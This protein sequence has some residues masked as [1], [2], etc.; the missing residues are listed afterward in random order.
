PRRRARIAAS[1]PALRTRTQPQNMKRL[2]CLAMA[3][4]LAYAAGPSRE[5]AAARGLEFIYQTAGDPKNFERYGEDYLW[6]F[7]TISACSR[8]PALARRALD[9]GRERAAVW[10][11][12]YAHLPADARADQIWSLAFGAY[13]AQQLG[14]ADPKLKEQIRQGA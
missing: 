4:G 2:V 12:D 6:C 5:R 11:R 1:R 7:Y 14:F 13:A 8:D 9:M 10:V 3:A